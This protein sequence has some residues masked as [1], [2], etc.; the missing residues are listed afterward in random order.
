[1]YHSHPSHILPPPPP[2]RYWQC[3]PPSSSFPPS[4]PNPNPVPNPVPNPDG[5]TP[6]PV[7][8]P[9]PELPAGTQC[10]AGDAT[11]WMWDQCGGKSCPAAVKTK[12]GNCTDAPFTGHCCPQGSVCSRQSEW[13][14]QCM[15]DDS[16][17][18]GNY[19]GSSPAPVP[20]PGEDSCPAGA[21]KLPAWSQCGGISCPDPAGVKAAG[22]TCADA[23]YAGH[24]CDA[25]WSCTRSNPWYWQCTGG[26]WGTNGTNGGSTP[27]GP[28]PGTP[29]TGGPEPVPT[30]TPSPAPAMTCPDGA[31]TLLARWDQCG[32]KS[33][34]AAVQQKV[35]NC[36]DAEFTGYCCPTDW[37]CSRQH[38]WYW[39]CLPPSGWNGGSGPTPTPSPTPTPTPTPS[40][41]VAMWTICGGRNL[42]A[43][44]EACST[45]SCPTD[46]F[47]M[48]FNEYHWQCEPKK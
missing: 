26:S 19:P 25:G 17:V 5:S 3:L 22:G 43:K 41:T 23:P 15:P 9:R 39:Q 29:G 21:I 31:S 14:H 27:G 20:T 40:G 35:G 47:C 32:G 10:V 8:A 34:P 38:E 12:I 48:R 42:C 36:T 2:T 7:P 4:S 16:F 6:A 33:C 24:C 1:M 13:Y 30:P 45:V 11:L 28:S 46:G 44:D 37:T 18:S